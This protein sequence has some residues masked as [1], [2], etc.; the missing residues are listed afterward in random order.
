MEA[1]IKLEPR[2][3]HEVWDAILPGLHEIKEA[4]PEMCTWRVEDV[5]T[6]LYNQDAVVYVVDDGFAV[7]YLD[8]DEY[9]QES[10]LFIWIA[11]SPED[12]RGGMLQK[13]LPSFIEVAKGLGCRGVTTNSSHPALAILKE[14]EPVYTH[15]RVKIDGSESEETG[16][17]AAGESAS[18]SKPAAT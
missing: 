8:T 6:A 11:Y 16:P 4:W 5:Y 1:P 15:Y 14:L 13:Y 2:V 10:D 12:R 3:L 17:D 7:C 18:V 9:S